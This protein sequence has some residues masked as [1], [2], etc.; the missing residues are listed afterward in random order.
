MAKARQ[1]VIAARKAI[2]EADRALRRTEA[3][4]LSEGIDPESLIRQLEAQSGSDVK[5]EI[6]SMVTQAMQ[7]VRREA[8]EAIREARRENIA[9]SIKRRPRQLI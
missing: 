2:A 8:D 1:A 6:E 9:S 7:D 3:Y 4:F 5:R